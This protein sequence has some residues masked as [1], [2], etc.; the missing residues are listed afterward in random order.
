M[1]PDAVLSF[2][3]A[4]ENEPRWFVKSDAFDSEIRD[5]FSNVYEQAANA[6][7][8]DWA[9]TMEGR[10][11]LIIVLDQFPRNMFRGS[12]RTFSSDSKAL[13]LTKDGIILGQDAQ[14]SGEALSFF[15]MPLMHSENLPDQELSVALY[16]K[17]SLTNANFADHVTYAI[18]HRDIIARFGRFPHR[19]K[20]LGRVTTPEEE[21]FLKGP[22][23]SF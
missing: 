3:F 15:Y 22:M 8:D 11:A 6:V 19:N 14:L 7:L 16:E 17:A 2:W 12:P 10:L 5:R 9:E 23:S 20:I 13:Q 21:E 18:A 4:P 1:T